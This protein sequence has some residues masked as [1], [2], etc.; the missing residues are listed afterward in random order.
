[1]LMTQMQDTLRLTVATDHGHIKKIHLA[2][3]SCFFV[4][5]PICWSYECVQNPQISKPSN[6]MTGDKKLATKRQSK[7][8][9]S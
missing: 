2:S 6:K 4:A 3:V 8:N 5:V 9:E 1:M 7:E